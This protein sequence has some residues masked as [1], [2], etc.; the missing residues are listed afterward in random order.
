MSQTRIIIL[1]NILT[2]MTHKGSQIRCY[3]WFWLKEGPQ[4]DWT[5]FL[6]PYC[7]YLSLTGLSLRDSDLDVA[8]GHGAKWLKWM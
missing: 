1:G 3:E 8:I 5:W 4:R 2:I 7:C 6:P